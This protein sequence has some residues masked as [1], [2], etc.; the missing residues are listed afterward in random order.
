[1]FGLCSMA[2]FHTMDFIQKHTVKAN[3]SP[4]PQVNEIFSVAVK[5]N[6][7]DQL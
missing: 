3:F 6:F 5:P 2:V 7:K 1:M 4:T